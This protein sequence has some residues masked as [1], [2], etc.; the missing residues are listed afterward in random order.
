MCTGK[1]AIDILGEVYR[2]C[3]RI[4]P[5]K[6][7]DAFLYGSYARGDYN[8]E[9]DIDI[10]LVIDMGVS[11]IAQRRAKLASVTSALSLEHDITVSVTVKPKEQFSAYA[12][13]LPF[14]KNVLREGVR[15]AV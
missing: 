7:N 4:Y 13:V 2:E 8:E 12:D 5:N 10:L 6:I 1:Q 15:Y 11:E 9:S 14:Y 3:S